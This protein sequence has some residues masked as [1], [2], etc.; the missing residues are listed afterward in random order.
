MSDSDRRKRTEALAVTA[1]CVVTIFGAIVLMYALGLLNGRESER[2]QQTPAAYSQS[3]QADAERACAGAQSDALFECVYERVEASQE[4]ARGEQ[5]LSAQQRAA[6]AA[7]ASAVVALLTLIISVIGVWFVKRT[8]DATLVAVEDNS[9]ATN[10]MI[11]ANNI[12]ANADRPWID[13]RFI[14]NQPPKILENGS[15]RVSCS[16]KGVNVGKNP[17]INVKTFQ[18]IANFVDAFEYER[19]L[20]LVEKR[21]MSVEHKRAFIFPDQTFDAGGYG[22]DTA[23]MGDPTLYIAV[24][25]QSHRSDEVYLTAAAFR[26]FHFFEEGGPCGVSDGEMAIGPVSMSIREAG[27][28]R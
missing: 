6:S 1:F 10:A 14:C 3:A 5:D 16:I 25:Y 17:A 15:H 24:L 18:H 19:C 4:Q 11:D 28:V 20:D 13:F 22:G 21:V 12:A 27:R 9:I 26:I 23:P 8:L 2:R 7:L